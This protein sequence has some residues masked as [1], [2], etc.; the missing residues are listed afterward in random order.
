M[1]SK[2]TLRALLL[3]YI[4]GNGVIKSQI[5]TNVEEERGKAL[6]EWFDS[7]EIII[8]GTM[9]KTNTIFIVTDT[10][11][12]YGYWCA[13]VKINAILKGKLNLGYINIKSG[14]GRQLAEGIVLDPEPSNY[15]DHPNAK[16][17]IDIHPGRFIVKIKK[18][19]LKKEGFVTENEGVYIVVGEV[20]YINGNKE[21]LYRNIQKYCGVDIGLPKEEKKSPDAEEKIKNKSS[22]QQNVKNYNEYISHLQVKLHLNTC[23]STQATNDLTLSFANAVINGNFFEF[24]VMISA[25]SNTTYFDNALMRI[26]YNPAAFG[27]NIVSN[28]NVTITKGATFNSVTYIDP[29]TNA[30]DQTSSQMGVPFG[31]DFNQTS[32]NRTLITTTPVQLLHFKMKIINCGNPAN[33]NF[34]DQSFTPLFSLYTTTANDNP[35]N[36]I[37]YDNT[38]YSSGLTTNLTCGLQI[39]GF[40]PNSVIAGAF[41]PGIVFNESQLT[42]HGTGFGNTIGTIYMRNA[43]NNSAPYYIPLDAYDITSWTDTQ[44]VL[45]V[46]SVLFSSPN[47]PGT[48]YIF[49]KPAGATDSAQSPTKVQIPYILK[50]VSINNGTGKRRISFAYRSVIDSAGISDTAAYCFRFDSA[51][52][53][54]NP[55]PYCRPLLKQAIQDWAC[56]LPI[57]YRIGKDTTITN[58]SPDG[59]SYVT[60]KPFL[61]D[62]SFIAETKISVQF[63]T[64]NLYSAEADITFRLNPLSNGQPD[65]FYVNP[66]LV[67]LGSAGGNKP[68]GFTDFFEV[69]LHEL[70]HASLLNHVNDTTDLMYFKIFQGT[71][72]KYISSND[73]NGGI[74]N[75]TWSKTLTFGSCPFAPFTIPSSGS[76]ACENISGIEQ[77]GNTSF[78]VVVYP[79]PTWD[80][81]NITFT[82]SKISKNT[83][84][85]TDLS[86]R[87]LFYKN[88]GSNEGAQEVINLKNFAKGMYILTITDNET[89]I[90]MKIILQ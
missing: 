40:T 32:W 16:N 23:R 24:D 49:V 6:K 90:N 5:E 87:I 41:Y 8:D 64:G 75:I 77:I 12:G 1:K 31:T 33:I 22:Y 19:N 86:G 74:D 14:V 54:G 61:S 20:K 89:I 2:F 34:G 83:I 4:I 59:I 76:T 11:I 79:N 21:E 50:N 3:L 46:P 80:Y 39:T 58:N 82:K 13:K 47:Y 9:D 63:C 42:I 30:I 27:N 10:S 60:F 68:N 65:W 70:G 66:S 18:S 69:A 38:F 52:V 78:E 44:I 15:Y 37:G 17:G 36:A 26:D 67:P 43:L 62:L 28:G 51:T 29:N 85:L 72:R 73:Q 84:K 53:T 35:A 7:G 56:G 57:R 48:G 45:N 88:I 81:L 55:N 71:P 25:N